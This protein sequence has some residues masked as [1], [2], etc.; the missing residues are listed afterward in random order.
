VAD[1]AGVPVSV[2]SAG[3]LSSAIDAGKQ[4]GGTASEPSIDHSGKGAIREVEAARRTRVARRRRPAYL[5]GNCVVAT[6]SA[7]SDMYSDPTCGV[8]VQ[9]APRLSVTL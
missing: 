4:D 7:T 8:A 5:G 9:A 3:L 6:P 1:P 2:R